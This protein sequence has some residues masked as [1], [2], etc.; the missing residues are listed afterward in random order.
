MDTKH[1]PS[2]HP[3]RRSNQQ[4]SEEECIAVLNNATS[5]VLALIDNEKYPYAVPLSFAYSENDNS[6]YFHSALSG[7][8]IDALRAS[9]HASFCVI[10]TDSVIPEKLTTAYKSVIAFGEATILKDESKCRYGLS[11]LAK[12]YSPTYLAE[13]QMEIDGALSRTSVIRLSINHFS[14][15]QGLE[16]IQK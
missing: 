12:K 3:M 9:S 15:K 14:G 4:L 10:D 16:L 1:R 5:G 6:I 2:V 13:A 11:L 8:K 7:H